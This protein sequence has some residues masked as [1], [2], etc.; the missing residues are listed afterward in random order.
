MTTEFDPS[1][2]TSKVSLAG[3]LR[4]HPLLGTSYVRFGPS[5]P[6]FSFPERPRPPAHQAL[7]TRVKRRTQPPLTGEDTPPATL[8]HL[9]S[10]LYLDMLPTGVLLQVILRVVALGPGALVRVS[11]LG[12]LLVVRPGR[13]Q[14][15]D[16][17]P[18]LAGEAPRSSVAAGELGGF[19]KGGIGHT[20]YPV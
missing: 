8:Q 11:T 1:V 15:G 6:L 9:T 3:M 14:L 2:K 10:T 17:T 16:H 18:L 19:S 12:V 7:V 5:Q 20:A 4:P 13:F